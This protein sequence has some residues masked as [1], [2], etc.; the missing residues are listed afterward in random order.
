MPSIAV[1]CFSERAAI[2]GS[3]AFPFHSAT[4]A[5]DFAKAAA[6]HHRKRDALRATLLDD[7][8]HGLR[9]RRDHHQFDRLRDLGNPGICPPALNFGVLGIDRIQFSLI[10]AFQHVLEHNLSDRVLTVA[11]AKHGH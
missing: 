9:R 3:G 10:S 4:F 7:A 8:R 6:Q 2:S 5:A 1:S 11:G